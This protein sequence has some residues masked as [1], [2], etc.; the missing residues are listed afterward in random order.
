MSSE[1]MLRDAAAPSDPDSNLLLRWENTV[2]TPILSASYDRNGKAV[3]GVY[4][5]TAASGSTINITADDPKNEL[6]GTGVAVT[7]DGSTVNDLGF[8]KIV[9]SASLAAGWTGKV[10]IGALMA[11]DGSTSRRLDVGTV[12]SG[13][14]S[15]QRKITAVNVGTEDSAETAVYALPGYFIEGAGVEDFV[16]Y[17]KN[18]TD[19]S[20]HDLAVAGDYDIT[21][22]DYVAGPP[23]THDVWVNDGGGAV[24]CIEDAQF[25]GT[26]YQYGEG[27]GYIDAA[28]E[29]RGLAIAFTTDPGDASSKTFT[30]HVRESHTF[31]EFA[32]DV[33]G[34]PGTWQAGPLTLTESGQVTGV[35]TPSGQVHFWVRLNVPSSANP[36]DMRL[37]VLRARG[38][39]V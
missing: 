3:A 30:L 21:F 17:V 16:A 11:T 19:P 38:L 33:S 39:T 7:A 15:T 36:G 29:L 10:S 18:H 32:P 9:F 14:T 26:L 13:S 35:I 20:R 23:Q 2:N 28:D 5:I 6:V 34:S 1:I 24:K 37:Y 8:A 25:D 4:T 27:N 12:E 22:D 31:V